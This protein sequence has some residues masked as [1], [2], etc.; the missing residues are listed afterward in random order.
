MMFK[1]A[2]SFVLLFSFHLFIP[3]ETFTAEATEQRAEQ[4]KAITASIKNI[5]QQEILQAEIRKELFDKLREQ[6]QRL[7]SITQ[8]AE[9][10][11]EN[12]SAYFET[13]D[14]QK[15]TIKKIGHCK[16]LL[17]ELQKYNITAPTIETIVNNSKILSTLIS[18]FQEHFNNIKTFSFP[19]FQTD[20]NKEI[21]K[22]HKQYQ[23]E[24][25]RQQTVLQ[26]IID[27]EQKDEDEDELSID[28]QI[29]LKQ[30][31]LDH[32]KSYLSHIAILLDKNKPKLEKLLKQKDQLCLRWIQRIYTSIE[33][34]KIAG[35]TPPLP[36]KPMLTALAGATIFAAYNIDAS[37]TIRGR[38]IQELLRKV[39]LIGGPLAGLMVYSAETK[40]LIS[41][42]VETTAAL[43]QITP[44]E[45]KEIIKGL[46]EKT[47]QRAA[48]ELIN[49]TM[50]QNLGLYNL[51]GVGGITPLIWNP[52]KNKYAQ[53]S[54]YLSRQTQKV[55]TFFRGEDSDHNSMFK[56]SQKLSD[57]I[58]QA[59][60]KQQI[61]EIIEIVTNPERSKSQ[62]STHDIGILTYGPPG[63]GKTMIANVLFST[64][65]R[66]F[67]KI[68]TMKVTNELL[69]YISITTLFNSVRNNKGMCILY[70]DEI[71]K[72]FA[73]DEAR[74]EELQK[75]MGNGENNNS[76]RIIAIAATNHPKS[77]SDAFLRGGRF[78]THILMQLPTEK[79]RIE[80]FH[81]QREDKNL[82]GVP[83][84]LFESLAKEAEGASI[85]DLKM[86]INNA[87]S[88]SGSEATYAQER[89]ILQY[90]DSTIRRIIPN[91]T[92]AAEAE[93]TSI[94]QVGIGIARE[95][96][97]TERTVTCLTTN[98]VKNNIRSEKT[99]SKSTLT[100]KLFTTRSE[101]SPNDMEI[102]KEIL[103][104][105]AGQI[106]LKIIK[107]C[108]FSSYMPEHKDKVIEKIKEFLLEDKSDTHENMQKALEIKAK[109]EYEIFHILNPHKNAI[110]FLAAKLQKK[111]TIYEEEWISDTKNIRGINQLSTNLLIQSIEKPEILTA[112]GLD[113]EKF[114]AKMSKQSV[115]LSTATI[116]QAVQSIKDQSTLL[117]ILKE[118]KEN[119]EEDDL[120]E[121]DDGLEIEESELAKA[122][123]SA[124]AQ[125][126]S[127][128]EEQR[129]D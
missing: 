101:S 109:L 108:K 64:L 1:R 33:N 102:K 121:D 67:P 35:Y 53:F 129:T 46:S 98:K 24:E 115:Y 9:S 78:A 48:L 120:E 70:F 62:G 20:L 23:K 34:S 87:I 81:R 59:E 68:T 99:H 26:E 124:P 80:A 116:T 77:L 36:S 49:K 28:T 8:Q 82:Y 10:T 113:A 2:F 21:E 40:E 43:N 17:I 90:Y 12:R 47:P 60:A 37:T 42:S 88:K 127:E 89:H 7:T 96:L 93:K 72:I 71:D 76:N 106:A 63:T 126:S 97:K 30:L 44:A 69:Q 73:E 75:A 22:A 94:Y 11:I 114:A 107:K 86:I 15:A 18:L 56:G 123:K 13:E 19:T 110:E 38:R 55:K 51:L 25:E 92:P 4:E 39:P 54:K 83:K 122:K 50:S 6:F 57:I 65:N 112:L 66:Q 14:E 74:E 128:L 91:S 125:N 5:Q 104:L 84:E 119:P 29:K 52:I 103:V 100:G 3:I 16:K 105:L 31:K 32:E 61:R 85:I 27:Q 95:L 111:E 79:E 58:G 118:A 45:A 117:Q 41:R